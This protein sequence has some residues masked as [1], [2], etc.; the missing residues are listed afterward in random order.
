MRN[1]P[2]RSSKGCC[3]AFRFDVDPTVTVVSA[4]CIG[5][6]ILGVTR[7][8]GPAWAAPTLT[9]PSAGPLVLPGRAPFETPR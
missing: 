5:L 4:V 7:A 6:V 1:E 2:R 8:P 3:N 9:S